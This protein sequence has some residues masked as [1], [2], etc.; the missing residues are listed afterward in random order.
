MSSFTTFPAALSLSGSAVPSNLYPRLLPIHH[1]AA[2][3]NASAPLQHLL[4]PR[5]ALGGPGRGLGGVRHAV[6]VH[7]PITVMPLAISAPQPAAMAS[8]AGD[9]AVRTPVEVGN[10]LRFAF[11]SCAPSATVP[12][13][14]GE[15][16]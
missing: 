5:P 10:V 3:G 13:R 11:S 4:G 12:P 2:L 16:G 15:G 8:E 9:G 6:P 14:E 1:P 7:F